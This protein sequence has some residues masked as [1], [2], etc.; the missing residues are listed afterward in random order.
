MNTIRTLNL[1]THTVR[2]TIID[3]VKIYD[4]IQPKQKINNLKQTTKWK[5]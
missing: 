5:Q 4:N 2:E 3:G 1:S